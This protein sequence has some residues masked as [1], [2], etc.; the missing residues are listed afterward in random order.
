M[1]YKGILHYA[2]AGKDKE[3]LTM[4]NPM[5]ILRDKYWNVLDEIEMGREI[6]FTEK[7]VLRVL[8]FDEL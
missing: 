1:E 7:D 6:L 4:R 3:G 8:F 5:L 2:D